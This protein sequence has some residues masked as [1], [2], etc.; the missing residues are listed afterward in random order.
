MRVAEISAQ[1]PPVKNPTALTFTSVDHNNTSVTGYEV[2]ILNGVSVIQTLNI[3]KS[4][5][6]AVLLNR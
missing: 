4:A 5:T 3:G 2:D 1:T 6:S